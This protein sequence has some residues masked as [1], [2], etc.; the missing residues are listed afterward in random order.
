MFEDVRFC[1]RQSN[2]TQRETENNEGIRQYN[3]GTERT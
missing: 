1:L 3:S 2:T